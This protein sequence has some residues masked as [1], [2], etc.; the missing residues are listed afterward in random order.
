MLYH[1]SY[2]FLTKDNFPFN[3]F[4]Y[5]TLAVYQMQKKCVCDYKIT[6]IIIKH[7]RVNLKI[8]V[9]MKMYEKSQVMKKIYTTY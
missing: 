5:F 9:A 2:S 6:L 1:Q 8:I 7:N 3:V 4:L